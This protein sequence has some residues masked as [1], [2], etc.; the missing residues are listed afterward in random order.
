MA[1]AVIFIPGGPQALVRGRWKRSASV[2]AAVAVHGV[3]FWLISSGTR[4][5]ESALGNYDAGAFEAPVVMLDLPGASSPNATA[6]GGVAVGGVAEPTPADLGSGGSA[7]RGVGKDAGEGG[8]FS[9]AEAIAA[10]SALP[11]GAGQDAAAARGGTRGA[12]DDAYQRLL[13]KHIRA[14]RLYP[15][16]AAQR[17]AEG[18]V[19]IR[20]RVAR[21]GQIEEAWIARRSRDA[22]LDQAALETLWRAEPLPAVPASLPAPAEVELPVPFRL[23]RS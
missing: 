13:L 18:I 1:V 22:D 10:V 19:V 8:A 16:E 7:S 3:L 21:D 20:F 14:F 4:G 11:D 23:P 17:R 9:M 6:G 2:L 5:D 12:L 15:R